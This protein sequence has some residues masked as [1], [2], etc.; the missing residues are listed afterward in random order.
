MP[1]DSYGFDNPTYD[2]TDGGGYIDVDGD[3]GAASKESR[4]I[5]PLSRRPLQA[6]ELAN[7]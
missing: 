7:P 1:A 2:V 6:T 5:L 4:F 3:A